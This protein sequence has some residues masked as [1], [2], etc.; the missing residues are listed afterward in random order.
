MKQP[1][2][3]ISNIRRYYCKPISKYYTLSQSSLYIKSI[4]QN[5]PVL[6]ISIIFKK[7]ENML[8]MIKNTVKVI[9]KI[10]ETKK[11]EGIIIKIGKN[12]IDSFNGYHNNYNRNKELA[13][14]FKVLYRMNGYI[15]HFDYRR[16]D[17]M[18]VLFRI[19]K[20]K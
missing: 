18:I 10:I 6:N 1:F 16:I 12:I 4:V 15:T 19:E 8:E 3:D 14:L 9:K 20:I 2:N 13:E 11:Y 7:Y 5:T 17:E